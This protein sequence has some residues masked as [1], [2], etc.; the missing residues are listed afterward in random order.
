M[1]RPAAR[2]VTLFVTDCWVC[3]APALQPL[4]YSSMIS[5]SW[6]TTSR[7][8]IRPWSPRRMALTASRR[9]AGS[10]PSAVGVEAGKSGVLATGVRAASGL[11][12][13]AVRALS[14]QAPLN[15]ANAMAIPTALAGLTS[16]LLVIPLDSTRLDAPPLRA[17]ME[18]AE[19]R[20]R[21]S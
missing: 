12:A 17:G 10:T 20:D 19:L 7:L 9:G 16:S 21:P 2:E 3:E 8:V 1:A 14:P 5:R 15:S 11:E 18:E 13:G 4:K 6:R